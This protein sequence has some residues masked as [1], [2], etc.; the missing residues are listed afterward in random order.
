[1]SKIW[2]HHNWP[3]SHWFS[4]IDT[5]SSTLCSIS[6]TVVV[7]PWITVNEGVFPARSAVNPPENITKFS[8][9][10]NRGRES[11]KESES[12]NGVKCIKWWKKNIREFLASGQNTRLSPTYFHYKYVG[13][14]RREKVER[15]TFTSLYP[16]IDF[17]HFLLLCVVTRHV[18]NWDCVHWSQC[19]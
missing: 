19:L 13:V 1:M 4:Q 3:D 11:E 7:F 17:S 16:W 15:S 12:E 2:R 18:S 6:S 5:K 9:H 14:D 8:L 10:R